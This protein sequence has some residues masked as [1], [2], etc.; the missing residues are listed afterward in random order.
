[1]KK[2]SIAAL[3]LVS[4]ILSFGQK[5]LT[6]DQVTVSEPVNGNLYISAGTIIINAPVHGDLVVAGGTVTI[7][8]SVTNDILAIGG[9][10]TINGNTGGDVRT[11]GGEIFIKKEVGGD[12]LIGGGRVHVEQGTVINGSLIAGSGDIEMNGNTK[13]NIKIGAGTLK[14]NGTA[15][16]NIDC[17]A[18]DIAMNGTVNGTST[19]AAQNLKISPTAVFHNNVRYWT[20][21]KDLS[22]GNTIKSGKA[23]YD[24]SLEMKSGHWAYIGFTTLFGMLWYLATIFTFILIIQYF[25]SKVM[26]RASETAASNTLKSIGYGLLFFILVPVGIVILML[27]IVGIPIAILTAIAYSIVLLLGNVIVSVIITHWLNNRSNKH[28]RFWPMVFVNLG[29]FAV[30]KLITLTPF[31]GFVVMLILAAISFGAILQ[32]IRL[33]K[34]T[35]NVQ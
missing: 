20:K 33:R 27:T 28:W 12:L 29:V 11:G 18:G 26:S 1:M 34:A 15:G 31:F 3:L 19:L 7:N 4:S 2:I 25:F 6:G 35:L 23:I 14:M 32:N 13:G 24:P 16:G 9:T 10:I 21:N 22:F 17:R 5:T 30:Y 8:D